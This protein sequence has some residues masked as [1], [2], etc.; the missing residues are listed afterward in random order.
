MIAGFHTAMFA[1]ERFGTGPE[2]LP[3]CGHHWFSVEGK[4]RIAD[5]LNAT[6]KI[7]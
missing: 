1:R 3:G 5:T 4:E 7:I 2:I 6:P